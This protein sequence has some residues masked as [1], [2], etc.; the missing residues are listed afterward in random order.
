VIPF[1]INPRF[2][3]TTS[4]RALAGYNEPDVLVRRDV[5]GMRIEPYF[6]YRDVLILRGLKENVI[7]LEDRNSQP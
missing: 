7:T 6:R 3:G 1:E 5:L 4:L 2:S